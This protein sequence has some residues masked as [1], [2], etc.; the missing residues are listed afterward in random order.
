MKRIGKILTVCV[1]EEIALWL[2]EKVS[3]GYKKAGLI[4]H[5]LR[6]QMEFEK[7]QKIGVV[8]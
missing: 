2:D 8:Q 4:R 6:K 3:R 5:L 7:S 1:N